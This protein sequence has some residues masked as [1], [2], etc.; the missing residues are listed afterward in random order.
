MYVCAY[1]PSI[2]TM[3][4][5][6]YIPSII[7]NEC[8]CICNEIIILVMLILHVRLIQCLCI[9]MSFMT[10]TFGSLLYYYRSKQVRYEYYLDLRKNA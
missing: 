4:V 10:D 1:I 9:H 7:Y 3:Y 2:Y 8:M 5:C 6:V